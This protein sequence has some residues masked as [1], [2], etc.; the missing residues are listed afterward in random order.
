MF[1]APDAEREIGTEE[2]AVCSGAGFTLMRRASLLRAHQTATERPLP[3]LFGTTQ[4][5]TRI[6]EKRGDPFDRH[7][8]LIPT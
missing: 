3:E 2:K 4:L 8:Y 6:K 1:I 7:C 5:D